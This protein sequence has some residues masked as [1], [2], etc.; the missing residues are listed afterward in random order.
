MNPKY[1]VRSYLSVFDAQC[2]VRGCDNKAEFVVDGW[3]AICPAHCAEHR[4]GTPLSVMMSLV[5]GGS[6]D[7]PTISGRFEELEGYAHKYLPGD[8][9]G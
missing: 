7:M 8:L 5:I 2:Q 3:A 4:A 1:R 6:V 9:I